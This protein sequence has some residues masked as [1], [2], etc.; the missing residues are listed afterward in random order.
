MD[1][2]GLQVPA[3]EPQ[4]IDNTM[5]ISMEL[6]LN[7]LLRFMCRTA[8]LMTVATLGDTAIASQSG[9][10]YRHVINTAGL[11]RDTLIEIGIGGLFFG[12]PK[13]PI[14]FANPHPRGHTLAGVPLAR[15]MVSHVVLFGVFHAT[16]ITANP[17]ARD[18]EPKSLVFYIDPGTKACTRS[19]FVAELSASRVKISP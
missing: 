11:T 17:C 18:A 10:L 1:M 4:P 15:K 7:L 12:A 13:H 8:Y 16:F 3:S 9:E 19:D 5:K 2:R 6:D 14:Q